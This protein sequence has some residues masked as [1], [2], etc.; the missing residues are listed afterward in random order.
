MPGL[1][2]EE[3]TNEETTIVYV[4]RQHQDGGGYGSRYNAAMVWVYS[5]PTREI[6]VSCAIGEF[7]YSFLS[8]CR[9]WFKENTPAERIAFNIR[10][11]SGGL[12][13]MTRKL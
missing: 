12:D 13:A 7:K 6:Q 9:R 10:R 5:K 4:V 2:V 8:E 3:L 11:E 1:S